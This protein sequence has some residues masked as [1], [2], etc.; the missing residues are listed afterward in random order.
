MW[1]LSLL[2]WHRKLET[3]MGGKGSRGLN[4][5]FRQN[6]PLRLLYSCPL[7]RSHNHSKK[8]IK[9]IRLDLNPNIPIITVSVA[10]AVPQTVQNRKQYKTEDKLYKWESTTRLC[11]QN[12]AIMEHGHYFFSM[13]YLFLG[14]YFLTMDNTVFFFHHNG[15]EAQDH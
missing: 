9:S 12:T 2:K 7:N 11:R 6:Q 15:N 5:H 10:T 3:G 8:S 4:Q 1:V 13:A 14:F